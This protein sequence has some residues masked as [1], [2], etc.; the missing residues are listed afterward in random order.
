MRVARLGLTPVKG[1][2]QLALPELTLAAAGPLHDRVF[3]LVDVAAR[4]VVRTVEDDLTMAC[5]GRWE[6]PRLTISTPVGTVTGE[7]ADGVPIVA[8]Y[9]GRQASL[10]TVDGPWSALMSEYLG[11]PVV[12]CRVVSPG[13]VVWAG[14]VS[15][16]T[17]SSLAEVARRTGR[18]HDDGARFR[19]T[20]V[21]DT[22]DAPPFVEDG[23]V[24]RRLRLGAAVVDVT[25]RTER[26]AVVD[27]RPGA[28]GRDVRMLAALAQDRIEAGEITFGV[29]ADVV[30]PGRVAGGDTVDGCDHY[31]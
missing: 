1:M 8:D 31:G 9:W 11:R 2:S 29:H 6:P 5:T 16:V 28:G 19:A 21:I 14:P 4:R 10:V 22:G 23:W 15:L 26:C 30:R 27:R 20:M 17:T 25:G 12:L 18:A 3:C 7:V 24:G 13:A